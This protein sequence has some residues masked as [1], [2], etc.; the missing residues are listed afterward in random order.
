MVPGL[1]D[2]S[3]FARGGY[4]TVYR[5]TQGSV[6][7]AVAVKIENR[8]L[9]S[10]RD[11]QR[12]LREARA[13]GKLSSHPHVVDLFDAGVTVDQHPYLIME[14]CD[15]SY[16]DRM[17]TSPLSAYEAR[18]VGAKIA[19]ALVD[20]HQLGVLHRDVKPANILYS[21]LNKA[22]LADFG[23]AVL[24]EVRDPS[25]TLEALT[26]AYAAPEMFRHCAP[27][28]AVDV[29]ALCATLYAVM[30]GR[31]PRWR[32]ERNPSLVMLLELFNEPIPDL[33]GVPPALTEVLRWGM[34]NDPAARP[35]AE[36]LRD[37][38]VAVPLPAPARPGPAT[39]APTGAPVSGAPVS[40]TPFTGHPASGGTPPAGYV[41]PAP[42]WGL[43][44][45]VPLGDE[46][47]TLQTT[48]RRR[49]RLPWFLGGAG[50]LALLSVIGLGVW[51]EV[52]P[53]NARPN[54]V[55]QTPV[56]P[57]ATAT[58][59]AGGGALPGCLS[60]LSGGVRCPTEIECFGAAQASG[61]ELRA[62]RVPCTGRHT[63]ETYALGDLPDAVP[64]TDHSAVTKDRTVR[65]VCGE[66]SFRAVTLLMDAGGWRFEVL[67]PDAEAVADGDRTYRCVAGK[68]TDQ[69]TG[70]TLAR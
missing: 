20:A 38:L 15:G 44:A 40:G 54:P 21:R 33:P 59:T 13:A 28:P 37:L 8:T 36:Q 69:L 31:P 60:P 2:L 39:A 56:G 66:T 16:A 24:A 57:T 62:E 10:E 30:R 47:P 68:G 17:R 25:V 4:A 34:A 58:A 65:Q 6:G 5:A 26:P 67:P 51:R 63:W 50:V 32:D 23:L 11:Q 7:R 29:Y 18:D 49:R 52:S 46:T 9:D 45:V 1:S 64:A 70:P 41:P 55:A 19:D 61:R 48:V 22:S 53:G 14:L 3:V 35:S 43:Q 27:S 12:F 42:S